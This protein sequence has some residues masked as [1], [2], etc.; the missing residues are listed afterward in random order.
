MPLYP[1]PR[2]LN[3]SEKAAFLKKRIADT[4]HLMAGTVQF[5]EKNYHLFSQKLETLNQLR[6]QRSNSPN[7]LIGPSEREQKLSRQVRGFRERLRS[8]EQCNKWI[9]ND[10]QAM[11]TSRKNTSGKATPARIQ[12][13]AKELRWVEKPAKKSKNN[14]P[15]RTRVKT[16]ATDSNAVSFEKFKIYKAKAEALDRKNCKS[17]AEVKQLVAPEL[18][19]YGK[20]AYCENSL[21][22]ADSQIDHIQPVSK[23]GLST[24]SNCVLICAKCNRS[25]GATLLRPFCKKANLDYDKAVTRLEVL[26]KDV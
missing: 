4:K 24:E 7:W 15:T 8:V 16:A 5:I 10:R 3:G 9:E 6:R 26:G 22:F 17:Q 23:G 25:K 11:L 1:M 2:N 21:K 19:K 18:K 14:R 20:C 13:L 12:K